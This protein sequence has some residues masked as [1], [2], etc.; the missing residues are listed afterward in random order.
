MTADLPPVD[1]L[2]LDTLQRVCTRAAHELKGALNGV[3]VNLE[4]VRAR[5]ERPDAQA[6]AVASFAASAAEQLVTVI[7]MTEALLSL[8]RPA[9]EPVEIGPLIRRLDALLG[10]TTGADEHK[11][12][13]RGAVDD[14]GATSAG[15]TSARLVLAATLLASLEASAHVVCEA[16]AGDVAAV[17]RVACLDGAAAALDPDVVTVAAEQG[18]RVRPESSSVSISFP[19]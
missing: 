2:W 18:I 1:T 8:A 7:T 12:E 9:R 16:D 10:A 5:S 17:V 4:V 13:I 15:G 19:R 11:L 6:S 14:L 3:S